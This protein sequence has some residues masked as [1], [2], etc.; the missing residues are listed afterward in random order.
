MQ[1]TIGG[2]IAKGRIFDVLANDPGALLVAA[3]KEVAAVVMMR[4]T[5]AFSL[6]IAPMRHGNPL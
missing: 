2:A 6:I 3:A 1:Q 4:Q 5:R